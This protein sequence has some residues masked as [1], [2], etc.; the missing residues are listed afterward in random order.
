MR[1]LCHCCGEMKHTVPWKM[2]WTQEGQLMVKW[3]LLCFSCG[4]GMKKICTRAGIK[5]I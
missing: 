4:E 1:S 3:L 5:L 2:A